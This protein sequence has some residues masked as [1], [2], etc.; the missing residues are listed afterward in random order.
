MKMSWFNRMN[1]FHSLRFLAHQQNFRTQPPRVL[2][3]TALN[4]IFENVVFTQGTRTLFSF[5][6]LPLQFFLFGISCI[7]C[8]LENNA[9]ERIKNNAIFRKVLYLATF[10]CKLPHGFDDR[11][12]HIERPISQDDCLLLVG[13][14]PCFLSH[15]ELTNLTFLM[16]VFTLRKCKM[17]STH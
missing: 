10:R 16:S 17:A 4:D 7:S 9:R 11:L 12:F 8:V 5:V 2:K 1:H 3:T 6:R 15:Y 13:K 14:L